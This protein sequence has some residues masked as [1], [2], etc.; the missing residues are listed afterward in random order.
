MT[1]G[2]GNCTICGFPAITRADDHAPWCDRVSKR[3]RALL[4]AE[5]K[6]GSIGYARK[7]RWT[8]HSAEHA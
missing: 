6:K 2:A 4:D 1:W 5:S 3:Q 8:D 7:F